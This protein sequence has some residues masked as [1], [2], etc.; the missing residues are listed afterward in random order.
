MNL[1]TVKKLIASPILGD[2]HLG[3]TYLIRLIKSGEYN[4]NRYPIYE[5]NRRLLDIRIHPSMNPEP[6]GVSTE[7]FSV[8][9]GAECII[10]SKETNHEQVIA[11]CDARSDRFIRYGQEENNRDIIKLED[12]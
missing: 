2:V 12:E 6:G 3:L 8:W 1:D 7:D 10:Y 9:M 4:P 5:G 11:L